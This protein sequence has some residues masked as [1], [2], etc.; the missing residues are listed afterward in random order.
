MCI[1]DRMQVNPKPV[2]VISVEILGAGHTFDGSV[3]NVS[4]VGK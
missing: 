1:R 4:L 3:A 2:Y